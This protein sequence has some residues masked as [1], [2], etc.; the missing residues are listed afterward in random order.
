MAISTVN[1]IHIRAVSFSSQVLLLEPV[2]DANL[3]QGRDQG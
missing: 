3:R 2:D 1:V